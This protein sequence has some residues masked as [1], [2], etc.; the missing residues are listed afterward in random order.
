MAHK[1][2]NDEAKK[3]LSVIED[4]TDLGSGFKIALRDL[5]IRGAR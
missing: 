4:F 2:V 1:D 3:R 5:G